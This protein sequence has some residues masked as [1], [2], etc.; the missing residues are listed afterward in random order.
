MKRN[1]ETTNPQK[2]VFHI[3][4]RREDLFTQ[5]SKNKKVA[6][7]KR[8]KKDIPFPIYLLL[9]LMPALL[10]N[11]FAQSST[12]P[13]FYPIAEHTYD[14]KD[15]LP[16]MDVGKVFMDKTGRLHIN[17]SSAG[18]TALGKYL[19]GFDGGRAYPDGL[20]I[21]NPNIF[22][23]R[24]EGNDS[25]GRFYGFMSYLQGKYHVKNYSVVFWYD[26]L[27]RT[28]E[29]I[30]VKGLVRQVI[31]AEGSLFAV[32]YIKGSHHDILRISDGKATTVSG[33]ENAPSSIKFPPMHF[34]TTDQDFW[35]GATS[36]AIYRINRKDGRVKRYTLPGEERL[37]TKIMASP[38]QDVWITASTDYNFG[39]K[40]DFN[41]LYLWNHKTDR[42][43]TNPFKPYTWADNEM[44]Y[45]MAFK[46]D[47]G[48]I[49]VSYR[50]KNKVASA[51]LL[52][53]Q[54]RLFDYT[55]VMSGHDLVSGDDFKKGIIFHLPGLRFVEVALQNAV[56]K[57]PETAK[58]RNI[59]EIDAHTLWVG[60]FNGKTDILSNQEGEWEISQEVFACFESIKGGNDVAT[61]KE[62][63]TWYNKYFNYEEGVGYQQV[64]IMRY[65]PTTK[66]CDGF[67]LGFVLKRFDFREDGQMVIATES[68][69]LLW[70]KKSEKPKLLANL[71]FK[72]LPNQIL[73]DKNGTIW[74][75]MSKG[76]L[77]VDTNNG[78]QEWA[79]LIPGQTT[80]VMR[81]LQDK[82]GRLWVGTVGD[83]VIIY[84]PAT[85][86]TQVIDQARGLSNNIVVSLLEDNDGDIWAGTFYGISI[87]SPDGTVIGKLEETDGLANNECNRWSALKMKDGR[88][89]FGSVGGVSIIDPAL[90]KK[91][92]E[93]YRPKKIFL[94]ALYSEALG[95][96]GKAEDHLPAFQNNER[97]VLPATNRN[98][99]ATF[100]LSNYASPEKSTF[101]YQLEGI[102]QGWRFI[103][104]QRQLSLNALPAGNYNILIKGAGAHGMWSDPPIVIPVR[105]NEF[106]YLKWWFFVLCAL[107]FVAF[108]LI[109]RNRQQGERQRLEQEVQNRTATIQEQTEKLLE[110]DEAKTRLYTN[111]THEFRT[112]LT[113]IMGI[114]EQMKTEIGNLEIEKSKMHKSKL[115]N[116]LTSLQQFLISNFQFPISLIQRNSGNL[117][118]LVNQMLDLSKLESGTMPIH[119]T[120]DDLVRFLRYT[121]E[122]FRSLADEKSTHFHFLTDEQTLPMDFDAEKLRQIVVNLLSN[123]VKFTP[124]GGNIYLHLDKMGDENAQYAIIKVRDTGIGISEE[125]LPH[126]FERFYQ[127]DDSSTRKG[128][129]T[130]IGLTLASEL[131]N[132]MDG[133]I[134]V[135]SQPGKGSTFTVKLLIRNEASLASET[136]YATPEPLIPLLEDNMQHPLPALLSEIEGLETEKPTV[137]I[138]EDNADVVHYLALCLKDQYDLKIAMDGQEGINTAIETI[139]DLIVSDVMM[140]EKDGFELCETLKKDERTSHIPI[141]LLTAKADAE[142]RLAGL[143]RG[144]DAYLAKPFSKPEL[145]ARMEQLIALRQMFQNR[146]QSLLPLAP[147]EETHIQIEDAF[148]KK[149]KDLVLENLDNEELDVIHLCRALSLSRSQLHRKIKA[150]TEQSPIALVWNIRLQE[151][152]GLLAD[153]S[154]SISQV[155]YTV[156]FGYAENYSHAFQKA[157]GVSP[158]IWREGHY[159]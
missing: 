127:V 126:I 152:K 131:V 120:Q 103:G 47:K 79:N 128:E 134:N 89:C 64:K 73:A 99:I 39:I 76:L 95:P 4:R 42:F 104:T 150:L 32:A 85:G 9:V 43:T 31:Y 38:N 107:P 28:T 90:W 156:G 112:P 140:P 13:A 21:E 29:D 12:L 151:S 138:V 92:S 20:K 59:I 88:L 139:P 46:D 1:D 75:A 86:N 136:H 35:A 26:P 98:L 19:Y 17:T 22:W 30:Q 105:V 158:S 40:T 56:K 144:A 149:F 93:D 48:N 145:F 25:L 141:V 148:V 65:D 123:A 132:R 69:I 114:A 34:A 70:D 133:E 37:I 78:T 5:M 41:T 153:P 87:L 72:E 137:L 154:L 130:G 74:L 117:L 55:T 67:D 80:N 11:I 118:H 115:D 16:D 58:N 129:G 91:P 113:V 60:K 49:L 3:D 110:L 51:T 96:S 8:V 124:E 24:L 61:D 6:F 15:G 106:F 100:V 2:K 23:F 82:K 102:D 63:Y 108:F 94:T 157:F 18:S 116:D 68:S 53:A 111:I 71:S 33:F 54:Q 155:A 125:K 50:N 57:S 109:Y 135:T 142:S 101:A 122:S 81:V 10:N 62:Q 143:R 66:V 146:Y 45:T 36:N 27:T 84:E 44:A 52:D 14:I 121:A 97:I 119:L 77:K 147:A 83:G 159:G 7:P